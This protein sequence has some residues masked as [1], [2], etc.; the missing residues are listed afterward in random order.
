MEVETTRIQSEFVGVSSVEREQLRL[1]YQRSNLCG[2]KRLSA[3]LVL[4]VTAAVGVH[5]TESIQLYV[6]AA[7]VLGVVGIFLF[8]PLHECIHRTAFRSRWL[9]DAV[10]RVAGFLLLLPPRYFRSFHL[11]HH[12]HTQVSARDPELAGKD[13]STLGRYLIYISGMLYWRDGILILIRHAL[14]QVTAPYIGRAASQPI[15]N[16]ARCYLFIYVVLAV[17]SAIFQTTMLVTF[18]LVP[19]ILGQPVLRLFLLAEHTLCPLIPD[20]LRNSRTTLTMLP[21]RFIAWNMPYHAEH[22]ALMAIPFH[23]LPRAHMLFRDRIDYLTPG[24][25]KFHGRLLT[26]IRHENG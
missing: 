3:H 4:V 16:E 17:L 10:A 18:W 13:V 20:M 25:S 12:R 2:L 23:A 22:H 24:Y 1:L 7:F 15:I 9:N 21:V 5:Q 19:A 8:A 6:P 26:A 14:G 11:S